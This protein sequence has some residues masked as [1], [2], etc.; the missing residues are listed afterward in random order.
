MKVTKVLYVISIIS[1]VLLL[2]CDD[3]KS[4][5]KP[6]PNVI[7]WSYSGTY[8]I[9]LMS[10]STIVLS[11]PIIWEFAGQK[12]WMFADTEVGPRVVCDITGYFEIGNYF[13]LKDISIL[14]QNCELEYMMV[15]EYD[16][17]DIND[18]LILTKSYYTESPQY[19][20]IITL[21]RDS[22][23]EM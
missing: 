20:N 5:I 23:A 6:C 2:G 4:P 11:Q 13:T 8:Q 19:T 16:A 18:T 12:F 15:G 22:I 17:T 10:D 1:I 9:E 7:E 14:S 3:N 21:V